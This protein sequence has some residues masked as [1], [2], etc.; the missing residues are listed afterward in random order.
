MRRLIPALLLV[1]V[2]FGGGLLAGASMV[3]AAQASARDAY[4]GFDTL[5][6]V[7]NTIE[8][9]YVQPVETDE[10]LYGAVRGMVRG[11]DPWS[12]FLGP[13]EWADLQ[14]HADGT[15]DGVG[16]QLARSTDGALR[17]TE[18]APGGP[19]DRA[20]IRVGAHLLAVDGTATAARSIAEVRAAL[21]GERGE[22]VTLDIDQG[23]GPQRVPVIR[24]RYEEQVVTATREGDTVVLRISHFSRAT[25]SQLDA[26]WAAHASPE[27]S[28]IILDL[29]GNPGGL[30][31][32]AAAVVD[33]FVGEGLAVESR[34][35]GGAVLDRHPTTT[36]RDDLAQPLIVLVD[37]GSASAAEV[38]AGALQDRGRAT[39]VGRQTYGKGTV[40]HVFEL[41]DGSALK[42][43]L[44]RY[45][46]PSGAS[47]P[48][49]QGLTPDVTV[50]ERPRDAAAALRA[51]VRSIG[52]SPRQERDLLERIDAALP[53]AA[54]A[55]PEDPE[56]P[57]LEAAWATLAD[58]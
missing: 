27:P 42:L 25:R 35:R 56:D 5:A 15:L 26:A 17:V 37:E 6:R 36:T 54:P 8:A 33:R 51:E 39:L 28:A 53:P 40:Q 13:A 14:S 49:R 10:L 21:A 24:E 30:M 31:D 2:A 46:L 34:G 3:Q 58:R 19:A 32:Q 9:R 22:P 1:S 55:D 52:L 44:A 11:L 7:L 47:I 48:D 45:H 41:E 20:G 18:L 57:I 43:T 16:L 23:I 29:R 12:V 4:A 50:S 38:V